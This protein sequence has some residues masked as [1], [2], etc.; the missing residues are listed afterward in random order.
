MIRNIIFDWSGTL[1]D[2]LPGVWKATNHVL[3]QAGAPTLSLDEF[4]A[5]FELPFT[6][7]YDRHVPHVPLDQLEEWFHGYFG[8][9]SGDV[10]ALPHAVEFL[11]FCKSKKIR[12]F[13][14]STV[15][16]DYFATQAANAKMEGYFEQTFLGIWDKRKKI[17][18]ILD[19]NNLIR[20]ETLYVGDMQHDVDTAHHG[21]IHSVALLTGYNT[22]EQLGKSNPSIIT[23]NLAELKKALQENNMSLPK[24]TKPHRP[25][26]TVG[27][28][29]YNPLGQMLM[30][31]TEKWSGKWGIPGGKIEYGESS[32]SALQREI[33]EET[34]LTVSEIEFVLSQDSIESEEFHRTEHFILLNYTCHTVGETD[35]TLNEEA[36]EYRWVTEEEAL[37]LDLNLPTQVLLEAV[38]SREHATADA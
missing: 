23:T 34:G 30:I 1:V 3:E 35:V 32:T 36:Q 26:P 2:D 20:E 16:S 11:E 10:L 18:E 33:A 7:F 4:R 24:S 19:D 22:L 21:G 9:V 29:I 25:I 12:C 6:N 13:I 28:L 14:L 5:E 27:A 38:L 37:Q 15:N 8:Q 31:R 17:N